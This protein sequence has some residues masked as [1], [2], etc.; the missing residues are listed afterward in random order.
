M[1]KPRNWYAMQAKTDGERTIAELRIYDEIG[2]WG[3]TAGA[4]VS[5][6]N[7]IADTADE[8]LVSVNSIGGDVFDAFAIYNALRRFSGRVTT[9]VDGVAASAASLV[10]MAGDRIVMPE[11]AQLMIHNP[12]T[13]TAGEA[14][15]LRRVADM[16]DNARDGIMA[17]YRNKSGQDEAELI[18]MMD[19]E[20][21]LT[22][23][24]AQ[25][26]GM[27]DV[28]EAPVRLAAS[29]RS[30]EVIAKYRRT[31][32]DLRAQL[33]DA[34]AA[35]PPELT[36]PATEPPTG[37]QTSVDAPAPTD[38]P[39][40]AEPPEPAASL[41]AHVLASCRAAQIGHLGESVLL[42]C[43]LLDRAGAD[44]RI[45]QAREIAGLCVAAKAPDRAVEL[46]SAGLSVE[47]AR[48]RLF[49]TV[50]DRSGQQIDNKQPTGPAAPEVPLAASVYAARG[51]AR[52]RQGRYSA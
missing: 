42:S 50:I 12:W 8:V 44:A 52:A 9:R 38:V 14:S 24:E 43:G 19:E 4:F 34:P 23:L 25:A 11:N 26:L 32:E 27:C 21:W 20:T 37:P 47:Q 5:A 6:L 1:P 7:A 2:F 17:A 31:P 39:A 30:V 48:A 46:I 49:D 18:R 22:A 36:D 45:A 35:E 3:V 15:D 28:I 13:I 29:A 51:Q 10:V 33:Q 16:M 40:P 41:V